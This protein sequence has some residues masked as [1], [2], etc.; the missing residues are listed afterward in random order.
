[1]WQLDYTIIPPLNNSFSKWVF[2]GLV[3]FIIFLIL[4][5]LIL[6]IYIKEKLFN[7]TIEEKTSMFLIN[8]MF[9]IIQ[10]LIVLL[11]AMALYYQNSSYINYKDCMDIIPQY[12][13]ANSIGGYGYGFPLINNT[14][15]YNITMP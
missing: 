7:L 12:R 3:L 13:I 14:T 10:A 1:M 8:F 15:I 6:D 2:Y 11:L 4:Q 9:M 5:R